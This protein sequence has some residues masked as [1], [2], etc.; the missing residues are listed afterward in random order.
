MCPADWLQLIISAKVH[1]HLELDSLS[2][3]VA[4]SL[5][6]APIL[7]G[8]ATYQSDLRKSDQ[9]MSCHE[10]ANYFA[11]PSKVR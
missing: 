8:S 4:P 2:R 9:K 10:T 5:A 1:P 11:S 3:L 6:V 7:Q